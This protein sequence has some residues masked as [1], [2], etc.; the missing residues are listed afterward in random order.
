MRSCSFFFA[1]SS[2]A[3]QS[4]AAKVSRSDG[5]VCFPPFSCCERNFAEDGEETV[6]DDVTKYF[7]GDDERRL[8]LRLEEE[9]CDDEVPFAEE[10][11]SPEQQDPIFVVFFLFV[12]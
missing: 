7:A 2:T 8:L 9:G 10:E 4:D 12:F 1:E 11:L 5:G 3:L 6:E